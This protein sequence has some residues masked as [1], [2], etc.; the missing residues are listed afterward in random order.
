MSEPAPW[1]DQDERVVAPRARALDGAHRRISTEARVAH[2]ARTLARLFER[3]P[4]MRGVH[5]PA[6][7]LFDAFRWSA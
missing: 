5:L 3:R 1:N 4:D 6:D 2:Q 7:H